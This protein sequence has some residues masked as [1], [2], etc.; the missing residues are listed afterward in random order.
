[1]HTHSINLQTK[2]G[3][4]GIIL[5]T[6]FDLL[7]SALYN[8]NTEAATSSLNAESLNLHACTQKETKLLFVSV[9][10]DSYSV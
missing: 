10:L 9:V 7:V 4:K 1:M 3:D 5:Q 8:V 6:K 2:F